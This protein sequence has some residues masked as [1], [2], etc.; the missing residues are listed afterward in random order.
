MATMMSTKML[1]RFG[2]ALLAGRQMQLALGRVD[3]GLL[4]LDGHDDVHES[5][6]PVGRRPWRA[7]PR[8]THQ[9]DAARGALLLHRLCSLSREAPPQCRSR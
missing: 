2:A 3:A 1:S 4:A 8:S 7:P 5:I 6:V 9:T